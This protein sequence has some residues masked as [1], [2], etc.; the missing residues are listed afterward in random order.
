ML[1][2]D[3]CFGA[4]IFD[5]E[6]LKVNHLDISNRTSAG[7]NPDPLLDMA[8]KAISVEVRHISGRILHDTG[9]MFNILLGIEAVVGLPEARVEDRPALDIEPDHAKVVRQGIDK[10][11]RSE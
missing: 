3:H 7:T 2:E 4:A 8:I 5:R 11:L 9:C 1:R 10:A 6:S